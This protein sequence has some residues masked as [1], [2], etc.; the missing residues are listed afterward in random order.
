MRGVKVD[1]SQR[2]NTEPPMGVM[3]VQCVRAVE[4]ET[5]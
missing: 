5:M 1:F 3:T 4:Y 2:N